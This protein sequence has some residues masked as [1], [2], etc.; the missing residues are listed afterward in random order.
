MTAGIRN[1]RTAKT[2]RDSCCLVAMFLKSGVITPGTS[3][4][5]ENKP[6]IKR[7]WAQLLPSMES[8]SIACN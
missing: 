3:D 7:A 1:L 6:A 8:K 5:L 2:P 4:S